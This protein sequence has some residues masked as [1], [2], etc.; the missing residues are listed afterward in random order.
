MEE[1]SQNKTEKFCKVEQKLELLAQSKLQNLNACTLRKV[2]DRLLALEKG[3]CE[4]I[5]S[6]EKTG[7]ESITKSASTVC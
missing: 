1:L 5:A 2:E 6:N 3:L 7:K 4:E